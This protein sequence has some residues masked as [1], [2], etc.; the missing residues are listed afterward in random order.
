MSKPG[1]QG[2]AE[3]L[4]KLF[5][6]AAGKAVDFG[7]EAA[8]MLVPPLGDYLHDQ[9][10]KKALRANL[11]KSRDHFS[12]M[13][14]ANRSVQFIDAGKGSGNRTIVAEPKGTQWLPT[15]PRSTLKGRHYDVTKQQL[16]I[17]NTYQNVLGC[18]A[19][20][21]DIWIVNSDP[22][23]E[24][25][26]V[27]AILPSPAEL[28]DAMAL[29]H[30]EA[31]LTELPVNI[32]LLISRIEL[33][34]PENMWRVIDPLMGAVELLGPRLAG[35]AITGAAAAG[36]QLLGAAPKVVE[37]IKSVV[38]NA[39]TVKEN[40][41]GAHDLVRGERAKGSIDIGEDVFSVQFSATRFIEPASS[42]S[43]TTHFKCR[44][45]FEVGGKTVAGIQVKDMRGTIQES[46]KQLLSR[47][48]SVGRKS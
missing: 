36:H 40:A 46:L 31:Y 38:E 20:S 5:R 18:L 15:V 26:S 33:M 10:V 3:A 45:L 14:V 8:G 24:L 23:S 25:G 11:Q 41:E 6:K 12:A 34:D 29:V 7:V 32:G 27:S 9:E 44:G 48:R 42:S 22:T 4:L 47:P 28:P 17:I 19:A 2:H 35:L 30:P 39:S 13:N 43:V 16:A 37:T 1:N 21:E